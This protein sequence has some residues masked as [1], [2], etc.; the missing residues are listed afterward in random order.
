MSRKLKTI[1]RE[2]ISIQSALLRF[3]HKD[4]LQ[5]L[6]VKAAFDDGD[7]L[8]CIIESR[9]PEGITIGGKKIHLVQK[10]RDDYFFIVGTITG[11]VQTTPRVLSINILKACWFVRKRKGSVSWLREKCTYEK[12]EL[13][14][15]PVAS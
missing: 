3:R 9:M 13:Q 2:V 4:G 14:T 12:N 5:N 15:I 10:Y 6:H 1:L 11:E 8:H 7:S